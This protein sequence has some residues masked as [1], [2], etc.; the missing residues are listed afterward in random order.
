MSYV[1]P[2]PPGPTG[3]PE[4]SGRPT[5]PGPAKRNRT[6]LIIFGALISVV[7]TV[8]GPLA[9]LFLGDSIG[10]LGA[11]LLTPV[12]CLLVGIALLFSER[13]RPWGLGLLIGF[14]VMLI[15]GAGACVLVLMSFSSSY[16]AVA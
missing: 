9:A 13:T 14:F 2:P 3:P 5:Q 8:L 12:L 1:P 11:G 7:A 15:V 4:P 6:A 10:F 16:G